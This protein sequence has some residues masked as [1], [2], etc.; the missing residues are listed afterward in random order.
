[1]PPPPGCCSIRWSSAAFSFTAWEDL[2]CFSGARHRRIGQDQ[3]QRR[4]HGQDARGDGERGW[5]DFREPGGFRSA[6]RTSQRYRGLRRRAGRVRRAGCRNSRARCAPAIWPFS[7]PITAATRPFPAPITRASTCRCWS[8]GRAWRGVDLGLRA[9]LSDIGQTVAENFGAKIAHGAA[10]YRKSY[11]KTCHGGQLEDVQD[12]RGNH[13]IFREISA[14]GGANPTHCE[15]V[16]CPPFTSLAAAV[17]CRKGTRIQ[18]AR[19]ISPGPRKARLP[20]RFPGRCSRRGRHSRAGGHSE[21]R[22]YFGETDETV[23]KRTQAALEFGLT[24]IVCVGERLE[25]RES[26]APK[27]CWSS[28]FKAASRAYGGAIRQDRD[29]LR[30]G[31]G[32]RNGQDGHAGDRRRRASRDPRAR[33][34][35]SS[36][37]TRPTRC[38]FCT[39]AA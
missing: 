27:R 2:R 13:C 14:A 8:W 11:E 36:A 7:P 17:E 26:G 32:H 16:I 9:S 39:A 38:G 10:F 5:P 31:V 25:E 21:R 19:R 24:P 28:Q 4:R 34:A 20:A 3:E 12:A 33:R 1:V 23:L 15:I 37:R 18:L 6:V 29:R 35:R 22:Q 30:A